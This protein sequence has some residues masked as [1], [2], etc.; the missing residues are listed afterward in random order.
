MIEFIERR[1]YEGFSDE[2]IQRLFES[3]EEKKCY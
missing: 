3:L 2:N 1:D